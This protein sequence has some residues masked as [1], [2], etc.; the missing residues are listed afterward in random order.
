M[1]SALS[2]TNSKTSS[3]IKIL[4]CVQKVCSNMF[5]DISALGLTDASHTWEGGGTKYCMF[6]LGLAI[7][8]ASI[9]LKS[10]SS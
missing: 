7:S 4:M 10:A 8:R 3:R 6:M 5:N 9:A 2:L 1:T